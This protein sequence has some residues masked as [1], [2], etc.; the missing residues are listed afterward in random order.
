MRDLQEEESLGATPVKPA[1]LVTP[2]KAIFSR[3]QPLDSILMLE[4][5]A[6]PGGFASA[7]SE[8][9]GQMQALRRTSLEAMAE[10]FRGW[11]D[12][13]ANF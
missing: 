8:V 2:K 12:Q 11:P 5:S 3:E 1:N 10:L 6:G 9:A 4:S 7:K 13:P